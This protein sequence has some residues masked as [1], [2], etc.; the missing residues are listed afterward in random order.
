MRVL[1]HSKSQIVADIP[2]FEREPGTYVADA[3]LTAEEAGRLCYLSWS[4][5]NPR[6]ASN[7][8]YLLNILAQKHYSVLGHAA[9][10][11]YFDGI[12]RNLTHEFIRSRWFTFSEVSQRYVDASDLH[13]VHHP[14]MCAMGDSE[15]DMMGEALEMAQNAYEVI[16][17]N[18]TDEGCYSRKE[19]RQTARQVLP[20]GTE[21]KIL[22]SG[23]LR[24]WRDFLAQRLSPHADLEIRSLALEVYKILKVDF[25]GHF[26][27][28]DSQGMITIERLVKRALDRFDKDDLSNKFE[29]EVKRI[30]NQGLWVLKDDPW[31]EDEA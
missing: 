11:I 10:T 17:D 1:L 8:D 2:D 5:P 9:A 4:R 21:T 29:N 19:A 6:T 15:R 20:G 12:S 28:F 25:P 7:Q 14:G 30:I 13:F 16:V 24:A 3:D 22:V 26:Q 23:N 18:L 27:D 31:K